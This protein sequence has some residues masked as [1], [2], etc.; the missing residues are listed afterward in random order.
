MAEEDGEIDIPKSENIP[1]NNNVLP[2]IP[3]FDLKL[4]TLSY[5]DINRQ[6][7]F[8]KTE[9]NFLHWQPPVYLKLFLWLHLFPI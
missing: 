7:R 9:K 3:T 5:N 4:H 8:Q 2:P 6:S 1:A